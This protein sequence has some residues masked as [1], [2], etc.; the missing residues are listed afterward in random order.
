MSTR[1][2]E[3]STVSFDGPHPT[4]TGGEM[5]RVVALDEHGCEMGWFSIDT[6]G[7]GYGP[8]AEHPDRERLGW[9]AGIDQPYAFYNDVDDSWA[10]PGYEGAVEA[11]LLEHAIRLDEGWYVGQGNCEWE[12]PL[13]AP[14]PQ[15]L[16]TEHGGR[17]A[18][19]RHPRNPTLTTVTVRNMGEASA[20]LTDAELAM[21]RDLLAGQE[22]RP[23]T[24]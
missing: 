9:P 22:N 23:C 10:C 6:A 24:S 14:V 2:P 19:H 17:V 5:T 18:I 7:H 13:G 16:V 4:P 11:A 15:E 1:I 8:Q 12:T 3:I 21:L 20:H